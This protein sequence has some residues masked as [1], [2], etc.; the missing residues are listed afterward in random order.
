M[1][2]Q[3]N[4][5]NTDYPIVRTGAR[6]EPR[7][8]ERERLPQAGSGLPARP[9]AA[10]PPQPSSPRTRVD[11]VAPGYSAR[12]QRAIDAYTQHDVQEHRTR[13]SAL[14]GVDLYA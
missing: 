10:T 6:P 7:A 14:L 8:A 1:R 3:G 13:Y 5:R 2:I 9:S 4:P 12:A 11:V